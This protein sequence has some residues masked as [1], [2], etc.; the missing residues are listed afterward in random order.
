[1]RPMMA[2]V[3]NTLPETNIAHEIPQSFLLNTIKMVDFPASYVSFR[4][5]TLISKKYHLLTF[6]DPCCSATQ[7]HLSPP[8]FSV[9]VLTRNLL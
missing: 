2:Q 8:L 1:M 9:Y 3:T 7:L 6:L 5:A 4:E